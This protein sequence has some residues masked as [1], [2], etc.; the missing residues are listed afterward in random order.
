MKPTEVHALSQS[1][2]A[3]ALDNSR[4]SSLKTANTETIQT[5]A[6]AGIETK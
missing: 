5:E 1:R 4:E 2:A 6:D 3:A